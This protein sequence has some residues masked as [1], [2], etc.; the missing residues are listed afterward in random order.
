M[1]NQNYR[2]RSISQDTGFFILF[3]IKISYN[4][5][6][7]DKMLLMASGRCDIPAFFGEWF[8][9][10]L[11]EEYIDVRNPFFPKQVSRLMIAGD[12][13]DAILFCT[14]NPIPM[15][16]YTK[17]LQKYKC[18]WQITITP[19]S[20]DVEP[21][22]PNKG[23]L[24]EAVKE[25]SAI[26][27]K[28]NVVVRYDPIFISR[29][30]SIDFHEVMFEQLL[31]K[32]HNYINRVVISFIDMKKN[33]NKHASDMGFV[34]LDEETIIDLSK[35]L[36]LIGRKFNT[37]ISTCAENYDL[38]E[39]GITNKPCV[40]KSD[41]INLIGEDIKLAKQNNREH[42]NCVKTIDIGSYNSCLHFCKYCYANYDEEIVKSNML[43][44]NP[45]SSLIIGELK[46]DDII[47]IR[48]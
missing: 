36:G 31:G 20:K 42:C 16:S 15:F 24:I 35:R 32:L 10:R 47:K 18:H 38:S 23:K 33:T 43:L 14:K 17:Q 8:I 39:F 5:V 37:Q 13:I 3:T 12:K 28:E 34:E 46:K 2:T 45:K 26:Y 19:Y 40:D 7:G 11:Q 30:Y 29:R 27:G 21:Y 48:K 25:L 9:N 1:G 44:H 22:V 41:I 6:G 4:I